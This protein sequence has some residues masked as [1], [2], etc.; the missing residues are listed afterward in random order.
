MNGAEL[1]SMAKHYPELLVDNADDVRACGRRLEMF[2]QMSIQS[3]VRSEEFTWVVTTEV[4]NALLLLLLD[5]W[6]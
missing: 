6:S 4:D 3:A 5:R 2:E 1:A